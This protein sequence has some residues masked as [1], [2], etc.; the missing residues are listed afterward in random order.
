MSC[1]YVFT[2]VL[3]VIQQFLISKVIQPLLHLMYGPHCPLKSAGK[4]ISYAILANNKPFYEFKH[5]KHSFLLKY[6]GYKDLEYL[7][8]EDVTLYSVNE[9]E[10]LFVRTNQEADI[11]NV[12]KHPFLYNIQHSAAVELLV[13]SHETIFQYLQ[14]KTGQDGSNICYVHNHGRCGSTL[15]AAMIFHTNQCIVLSEPAPI[16][17]LAWMLNEKDYPPSRKSVEYINLVRATFLLTCPDPRKKYFI[18]PWGIQTL[19]LLP[20]IH[21]A[22]PGIKEFFMYRSIKPTV[23][24]F[25]KIFLDDLHAMGETAVSM[26]PTNYR[27][28]WN[29]MK[30]GR[31]E[32]AFFFIILCQIHAY[33]LETQDRFDIKSFTYESLMENKQNFTLELLKEVGIG[34]NYL[35]KALS[36]LKRD[37]QANSD[38]LSRE[39]LRNKNVSISEGTLN[40]AKKIALDQFEI[41]LEGSEGRIANQM[42]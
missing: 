14:N 29:K 30:H 15:L 38:L 23:L 36:A 17:N 27:M 16:V 9:K 18:K 35:D 41:Y 4:I 2:L 37:S 40:W 31:G 34:E 26:L 11:Y 8:C 5:Q 20:L 6:Q 22:L 12:E 19:S 10:F 39:S 32:E 3:A 24:S 42:T 13:A 21:Q 28:I 25:K 33:I 7:D 1:K